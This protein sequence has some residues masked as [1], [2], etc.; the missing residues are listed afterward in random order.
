M[1]GL[2]GFT[3]YLRFEG[4]GGYYTRP[5][6]WL[7]L[8]LKN[9]STMSF[10]GGIGWTQPFNS[11]DDF[12]LRG[13]DDCINEQVCPLERIDRDIKL[14]LTDRYFLGGVQGLP[15]RGFK[16]RSLGPRR[17]E[18]IETNAGG[19]LPNVPRGLYT[20]RGRNIFGQCVLEDGNCNDLNDKDID[21]FED[22]DETDV[23]G[24]SK[25]LSFSTEYRFPIS[26]DVGLVGI[27][28]LD[29][30]NAFSEDEDMFNPDDWRVGTGIGALW[31]SPFGPIE[32]FWGVPLDPYDDEKSSVF[33]FNV[34][35]SRI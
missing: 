24:G 26:E 7:P 14:P 25:F 35:G 30:G 28:F 21:D 10:S 23:I 15:L 1:A 8:P 3:K 27:L 31:F 20:A 29:A 12:D 17:S 16:E 33:E 34:G 11:V 4:R 9:R 2:G 22:L 18:L 6:R 13:P 32:V 19:F 5:P